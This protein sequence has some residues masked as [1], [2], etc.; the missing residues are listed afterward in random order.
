VEHDAYKA[1]VNMA[2]VYET[3][4][5]I[6]YNSS[7]FHRGWYASGCSLA[8]YPKQG[9]CSSV[10]GCGSERD[11]AACMSSLMHVTVRGVALERILMVLLRLLLPCCLR[12]SM[13][14]PPFATD[15]E[16][17][18]VFSTI[19]WRRCPRN[20]LSVINLQALSVTSVHL[21]S[22]RLFEFSSSHRHS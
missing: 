5:L 18:H 17:M 3:L 2:V 7:C 19:K 1:E 8:C 9:K 6:F 10:G 4:F 20:E 14:A 12:L 16:F 11:D 13:P 15:S 21:C 22:R